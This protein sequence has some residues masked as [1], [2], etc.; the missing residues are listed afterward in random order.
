VTVEALE[1]RTHLSAV[2][3]R[4]LFY[5]ESAFDG[6]NAAIGTADNAAIATDKA[7]LQSLS[8]ATFANYSS[9]SKGINGVMVDVQGAS[10]LTLA[11]FSFRAGNTE[12]SY[13]SWSTVSAPTGFNVRKGGGVGGSDRVTFTWSSANA[14]KNKWLQVTTLTTANTGLFHQDVFFVGSAIGET[15]NSAAD[16]RVNATDVAATRG[17]GRSSGATVTSRYDFNRDGRVNATDVSIT[18]AS[19]T[20]SLTALRLLDAP[21][22]APARVES[23]LIGPHTLRVT[24]V[25]HSTVETGYRID[26]RAP[27]GAWFEAAVAAPEATAHILRDLEA[28]VAYDVRVIALPQVGTAAA[29]QATLPVG[30][31]ISAP[32][33]ASAMTSATASLTAAV[34]DPLDSEGW[35]KVTLPGA[36]N[37]LGAEPTPG[38]AGYNAAGPLSLAEEGWV[39]ADS[40]RDAV[41][42]TVEGTVTVTNPGTGES[43]PWTFAH[44][45]PFDVDKT[46][47]LVADHGGSDLLRPTKLRSGE[48]LAADQK[49]IVLDDQWQQPDT[50][51]DDFYWKVGVEKLEVDLVAHRTGGKIEEEVTEAIEDEA[52]STKYLVLT[53]ND[54]EE[55]LPDGKRDYED[56]AALLQDGDYARDA[57]GNAIDDDLA[58]ITLKQLPYGATGFASIQLSDEE[59]V[60]LFASD[61]TEM[62]DLTAVDVANPADP[63]HPLAGLLARDVDVWVEGLKKDEDFTFSFVLSN[64]LSGSPSEEISRDDVH[65]TL[66][67]WTFVDPAGAAVDGVANIWV[68][69]LLGTARGLPDAAPLQDC[70][71]FK[72]RIEGL[73]SSAISE[74]RVSSVAHPAEFF[75]DTMETVGDASLSRDFAVLYCSDDDQRLLTTAER[76]EV[77]SAL[78]VNALHNEESNA[79]LLTA[80]GDEQ[81]RNQKLDPKQV[82]LA[83]IQDEAD[84]HK[85]TKYYTPTALNQLFPNL[86]NVTQSG[87]FTVKFAT[88]V[89]LGSASG[90][91]TQGDRVMLI[92]K[93]LAKDT[94]VHETVH[95][96]NEKNGWHIGQDLP[97]VKHDEA[98]ATGIELYL[99]YTGPLRRLEEYR[100]G[101][102]PAAAIAQWNALYGTR[103]VF[104]QMAAGLPTGAVYSAEGDPYPFTNTDL[105]DIHAKYKN[106]R[107]S[108]AVLRPIYEN[109]LAANGVVAA[110]GARLNLPNPAIAANSG[111]PFL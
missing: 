53:N 72:I 55:G 45:G 109:L 97:T 92:L 106:M 34:A 68:D 20:N 69:D 66:A 50:D 30:P 71:N 8:R 43:H 94:A 2:V 75:L 101:D 12:D 89:Q 47:E 107:F 22:N 110:G 9:Y 56:A 16:A 62:T 59:S 6:N 104:T 60:R 57:D 54:F 105:W 25:D 33:S 10:N 7:A 100:A 28:G 14:V 44:A 31:G 27:G 58:K 15:G 13:G 76:A 84:K 24:W 95:A 85:D 87:F 29:T 102:D 77:E 88:K 78:H 90:S 98:V 18:R 39:Y 32:L 64:S 4:H 73:A 35:F 19:G 96:W 99:R 65:M 52:D 63:D 21:V 61:G 86:T 91:Y 40:W 37:S 17:N 5:N 108:D 23:D 70:E 36:T 67:E 79:V 74:M 111:S 82:L 46:A 26:L 3:G 38:E 11:D 93:T 103:G 80:G 41:Y 42:Q 81:K 49:L 83:R 1:G 48:T 51:F